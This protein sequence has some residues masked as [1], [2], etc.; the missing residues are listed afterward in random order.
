MN[1]DLIWDRAPDRT[2]IIS[3]FWNNFCQTK[4]VFLTWIMFLN[5]KNLSLDHLDVKET[6]YPMNYTTTHLFEKN[7][8]FFEYM[9][10]QK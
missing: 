7:G 4:T 6:H 5:W 3:S 9:W 1:Y 10:I 8:K 2:V